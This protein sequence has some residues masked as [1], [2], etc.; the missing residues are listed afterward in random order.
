MLFKRNRRGKVSGL[1][2]NF[3]LRGSFGDDNPFQFQFKTSLLVGLNS[4]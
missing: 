1:F 2:W 4:D 3:E